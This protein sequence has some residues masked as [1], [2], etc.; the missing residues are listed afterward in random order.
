MQQSLQWQAQTASLAACAHCRYQCN[1]FNYSIYLIQ[2]RRDERNTH[3][4]Y[5]SD[6]YL[7]TNILYIEVL[8][9][10]YLQPIFTITQNVILLLFGQ[11][12]F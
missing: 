6:T 12:L 11:N 10:I 2:Q 3:L 8:E 4:F 9:V 7:R 1:F 5:I